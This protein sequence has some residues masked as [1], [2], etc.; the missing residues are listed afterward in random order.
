MFFI[1]QLPYR[2]AGTDSFLRNTGV[3]DLGFPVFEAIPIGHGRDV[4]ELFEYLAEIYVH[5][6]YL[7]KLYSDVV[8]IIIAYSRQRSITYLMIKIQLK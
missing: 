8:D 2:G 3:S 5:K 6:C 1:F 7:R 4:P